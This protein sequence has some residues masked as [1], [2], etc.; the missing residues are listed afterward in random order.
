ML[1]MLRHPNIVL[2]MGAVIDADHLMIVTEYCSLGSL[3]DIL[4]KGEEL[5]YQKK[6]RVALDASL[7]LLYLHKMRII[8]GVRLCMFVN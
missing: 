8:H 1:S 3:H 6:V 4:Y 7:G 5:D 2:F